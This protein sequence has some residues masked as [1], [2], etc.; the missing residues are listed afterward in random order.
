M[1]SGHGVLTLHPCFICTIM[2]LQIKF[3]LLLQICSKSVDVPSPHPALVTLED[4]FMMKVAVF[5][6]YGSG[7][8]SHLLGCPQSVAKNTP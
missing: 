5:G 1:C 4:V 8:R 7:I 6:A 3:L 2:E